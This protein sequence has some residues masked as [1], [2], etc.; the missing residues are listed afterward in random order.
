CVLPLSAL[1]RATTL[2]KYTAAQPLLPA[3]TMKMFTAA[4]ALERF[5]PD[6]RFSTDVL[7]DGEVDAAGTL[8]GN[9]YLRGDG[10]PSLAARYYGGK[11][12]APMDALARLVASKGI[13]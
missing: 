9:L 6:Y 1:R 11:A 3:S 13:K 12:D 2:F 8:H 4:L 7:R 10:D 5:G